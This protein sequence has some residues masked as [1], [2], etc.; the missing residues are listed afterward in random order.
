LRKTPI[1][2]PKIIENCYH[3]IDPWHCQKIEL[4]IIGGQQ[5]DLNN[6]FAEKN[7]SKN[8]RL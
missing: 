5:H 1:F 3:N 6:I 2:P 7:W 4:F 8:M